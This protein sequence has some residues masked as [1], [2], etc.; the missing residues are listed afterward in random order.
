MKAKFFWI[1]I[2][3]IVMLIIA[4][5]WFYHKNFCSSINIEKFSPEV[6]RKLIEV[7]SEDRFGVSCI[8]EGAHQIIIE[9]GETNEINCN[10]RTDDKFH[11]K[12]K[13]DNFEIITNNE[14][15]KVNETWILEKN[16]EG[17]VYP[18][19]NGTKVQVMKLKIPSKTPNSNLRITIEETKL[20][21][22]L[23]SQKMHVLYLNIVHL[24]LIKKIQYWIDNKIC[25]EPTI[26][27][28]DTDV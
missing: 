1:V 24:S 11:Y 12:L 28:I 6:E 9:P 5:V 8:G 21:G 7:F 15:I 18:G 2:I 23:S 13:V 25:G 26:N 14:K 4:G 19:G 10:I 27:Y 16:W 3:I 22:N 20:E 17:D